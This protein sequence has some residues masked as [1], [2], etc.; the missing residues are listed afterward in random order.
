MSHFGAGHFG[1]KVCI[2]ARP[3][4]LSIVYTDR[5]IRFPVAL[6]THLVSGAERENIIGGLGI[7]GAGDV[8]RSGRIVGIF[9]APPL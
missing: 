8:S 4:D 7:L 3:I 5:E 2:S 1:A 9:K 6:D